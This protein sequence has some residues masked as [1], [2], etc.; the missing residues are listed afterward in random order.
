LA[1]SSILPPASARGPAFM[2]GP[3]F[4]T[5]LRYKNLTSDALAVGLLAQN[6]A[7]GPAMQTRWPR[8]FPLLSRSQLLALQTALNVRC[9]DSGTPDKNTTEIYA[10]NH[11]CAGSADTVR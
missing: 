4:R 2:V 9:F 1:D 5:R 10:K 3:N 8:D 11:S 6:L 7:G